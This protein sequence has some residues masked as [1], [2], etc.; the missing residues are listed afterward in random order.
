MVSTE[1]RC[2]V[3]IIRRKNKHY[4][5]NEMSIDTAYDETVDIDNRL[6]IEKL[7]KP[8]NTLYDSEGTNKYLYTVINLGIEYIMKR[9]ISK[10]QIIVTFFPLFFKLYPK[11]NNSL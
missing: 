11:I 3:I 5:A 2:M 1:I 6:I 8:L 7:E 4:T 10:F 9:I